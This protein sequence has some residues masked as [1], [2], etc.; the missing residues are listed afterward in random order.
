MKVLAIIIIT[1]H[2]MSDRAMMIVQRP[3]FWK[4]CVQNERING[5]R[6]LRCWYH[7]CIFFLCNSTASTLEDGKWGLKTNEYYESISRNSRTNVIRTLFI[8]EHLVI[9]LLW[10]NSVEYMFSCYNIPSEIDTSFY[11]Y[12]HKYVIL[13]INMSNL[14]YHW[15]LIN[16]ERLLNKHRMP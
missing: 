3:I 15:G 9:Y 5:P 14:C 10:L 7:C 4:P 11:L 13:T 2:C 8:L 16:H 6:S 1:M 12:C